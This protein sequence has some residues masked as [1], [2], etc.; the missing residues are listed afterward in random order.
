MKNS[1]FFFGLALS[2]SA[3]FLVACGV[4]SGSFLSIGTASWI[5]SPAKKASLS[6]DF[7]EFVANFPKAKFPLQID[8]QTISFFRTE[9]SWTNDK[10][11]SQKPSWKKR[12]IADKFSAFVPS[13]GKERFSRVPMH[14]ESQYVANLSENSQFVAVL[15]S[16]ATSYGSYG[17]GEEMESPPIRFILA[18]YTPSGKII[19]EKVIA[20]NDG[21]GLATATIDKNLKIK[22]ARMDNEYNEENTSYKNTKYETIYR[23]A[24]NGNIETTSDNKVKVEDKES[25]NR[26]DYVF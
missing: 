20:Y 24:K 18:T 5:S 14:S 17:Y 2:F 23:I 16:T 21:V 11:T 1:R 13:L 7:Q 6:N 10:A 3:V 19:D 26:T 12:L 25:K 15:Y 8:E 9:A 22:V 4:G